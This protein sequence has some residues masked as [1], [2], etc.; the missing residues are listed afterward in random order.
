MSYAGR[1]RRRRAEIRKLTTR[2]AKIKKLKVRLKSAKTE[3]DKKAV[4]DK[5][6]KMSPTYPVSQ[7]T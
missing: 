4:L 6:W 1:A 3:G 5:I 7:L 2:S